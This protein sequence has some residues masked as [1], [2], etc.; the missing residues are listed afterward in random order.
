MTNRNP[1]LVFFLPCITLGIYALVWLVKT[2]D[3]M[4]AR[5]AEIPTAWLL[6]IP[7][8]G[9]YWVWKYGE[10]VEKITGG[11]MSGAIAFILLFLL[12]NIGMAILQNE[13][14]KIDQQSWLIFFEAKK[15]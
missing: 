12:G 1:I 6:I 3:E 9:L 13:Y 8:V 4:N 11:K 10:G 15:Q 7:I 14:N 2:K 5:G